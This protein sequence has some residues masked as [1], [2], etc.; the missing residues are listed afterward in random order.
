[1]EKKLELFTTSS[2]ARFLEV[3]VATLRLHAD[4][5]RLPVVR[6]VS[7]MRLF[8]REDLEAFRRMREQASTRRQQGRAAR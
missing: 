7:G 2:A 3:S 4:N 1:M 5:G 6:T 8:Q